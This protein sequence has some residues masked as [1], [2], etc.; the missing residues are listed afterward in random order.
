MQ[1]IEWKDADQNLSMKKP[2]GFITSKTAHAHS[3]L[4]SRKY[5]LL[6]SCE[7]G[8]SRSGK[9]GKLLLRSV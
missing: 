7:I 8:L 4:I 9:A 5:Q 2:E 1:A 3:S 6:L